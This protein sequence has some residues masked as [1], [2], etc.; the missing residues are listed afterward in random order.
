MFGRF[1]D[2]GEGAEDMGEFG[3]GEVVEVGDRAFEFGAELGALSFVGDAVV[4]S[5]N[6][7]FLGEVVKFGGGVD[8]FGGTLLVPHYFVSGN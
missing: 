5:A 6:A 2:D 7:D 1:G 3:F 8:K 4:V